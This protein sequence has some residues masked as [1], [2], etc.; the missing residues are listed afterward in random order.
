MY[1]FWNDMC[2][3]KTSK[4]IGTSG[5]LAV[6]LDFWRTSKTEVGPLES[7]P[8]NAKTARHTTQ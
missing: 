3:C 7:D 1:C 8:D 6:I 4:V 5:N 2:V